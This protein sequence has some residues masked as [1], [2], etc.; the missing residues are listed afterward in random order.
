MR[1]IWE[2]LTVLMTT[3]RGTPVGTLV[4]AGMTLILRGVGFMILRSSLQ[5]L[6]AVFASLIMG[7]LWTLTVPMMTVFLMK[8]AILV[9]DGMMRT[10]RVAED[11]I[12]KH[13]KLLMLV[14]LVEEEIKMG[15]PLQILENV[16][17]ITLSEMNLVKH[18]KICTMT[19][20]WRAVFLIRLTS[21]HLRLAVLA[22]G[23]KVKNLQETLLLTQRL[24]PSIQMMLVLIV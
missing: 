13:S 8:L 22:K 15:N 3:Q 23:I 21:T 6:S 4:L 20:Q 1:P 24:H 2:A 18:A 17:M 12:L 10:Q 19:I 7:L 16:S 9:R 14:V 5:A 11:G